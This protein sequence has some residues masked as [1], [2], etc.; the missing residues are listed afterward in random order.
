M[1]E[2]TVLLVVHAKLDLSTV[3]RNLPVPS[4]AEA[5]LVVRPISN[6]D[7]QDKDVEDVVEMKLS[8]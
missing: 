5:N 4:G 3:L 7:I 6:R 8:E 2:Y 1:E